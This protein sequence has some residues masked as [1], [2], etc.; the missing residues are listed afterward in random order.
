MNNTG[1]TTQRDTTGEKV[2]VRQSNQQVTPVRGEQDRIFKELKPI[3][4]AEI[5]KYSVQ[6][7]K[8]LT[9]FKDSMNLKQPR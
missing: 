4:R 5:T 2:S 8:E 9:D 1:V 7:I 3:G 6:K